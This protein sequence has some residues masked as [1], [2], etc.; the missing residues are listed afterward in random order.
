LLVGYNSAKE[1][2]WQHWDSRACLSWR[3]VSSWFP[4][5]ENRV[6]A[7]LLPGFLKWWRNWDED[8]ANTALHWYLES[9]I[10]AGALEGSIVLTQV[11]LELIAWTFLVKQE[12]IISEGGFEKLPASDK[13]RLLL[14]K[15]NISTKLPPDWEAKPV[16]EL[17]KAFAQTPPQLLQN[18]VVMAKKSENKWVDGPHAFTDLRNGIV[19][20]KKLKKVLNAES[21]ATFEVCSLGRWYLELVLLALCGYQGKYVNRLLIPHQSPEFVPWI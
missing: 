20:P 6:L 15:F 18:L 17:F 1:R 11:A 4:K 13:L 8:I 2:V 12:C 7:Q 19:H 5:C 16:P 3:G 14:S 9:N 10:N 21:G